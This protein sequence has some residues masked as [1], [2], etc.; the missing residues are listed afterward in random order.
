[1]HLVI[2]GV[3]SVSSL[4]HQS[5]QRGNVLGLNLDEPSLALRI[6]SKI[7]GGVV[8]RLV[9]LDDIARDGGHNVRGRLDGLDGAEGLAFDCLIACG[10]ELDVDNVAESF[11][12]VVGDANCA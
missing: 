1:M 12:G 9:D 2:L 6:L 10:G 4:I 8:Q 7:C 11:S 5:L 3:L